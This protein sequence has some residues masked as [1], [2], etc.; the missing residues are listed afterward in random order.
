MKMGYSLISRDIN[1]DE[2]L[3]NFFNSL[4]IPQANNIIADALTI[5]ESYG[6]EIEDPRMIERLCEV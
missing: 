3:P 2:D 4:N 6:I 5:Q 1:V